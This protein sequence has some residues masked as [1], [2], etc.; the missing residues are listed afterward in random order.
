MKG[1]RM[2]NLSGYDVT[3]TTPEGSYFLKKTGSIFFV[4]EENNERNFNY[5][6]EDPMVKLKLLYLGTSP[7]RHI[8]IGSYIYDFTVEVT[9]MSDSVEI[10]INGSYFKEAMPFEFG[11]NDIV[12]YNIHSNPRVKDGNVFTVIKEYGYAIK[13]FEHKNGNDFS[14]NGSLD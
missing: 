5:T 1:F 2:N 13:M 9:G 7:E 12:D 11:S 4:S 8:Q 14:F 10:T 6:F 3:I